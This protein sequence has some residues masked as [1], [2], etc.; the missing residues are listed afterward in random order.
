V[1]IK[2]IN[3]K[4]QSG[5]QRAGLIARL[6]INKFMHASSVCV[7]LAVCAGDF[8]YDADALTDNSPGV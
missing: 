2:L 6:V 8:I 3:N 7:Y 4:T 5:E 1:Q